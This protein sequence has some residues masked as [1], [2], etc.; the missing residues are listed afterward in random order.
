M[1]T[2][3]ADEKFAANRNYGGQHCQNQEIGSQHHR[4][5]QGGDGCAQRVVPRKANS[6]RADELCQLRGSEYGNGL[7][8]LH[9]KIQDHG[10]IDNQRR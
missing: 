2:A 4:Q 9:P 6:P 8:P 1:F 5:G 3:R 10:S 7:Q